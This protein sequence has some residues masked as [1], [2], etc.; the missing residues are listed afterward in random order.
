MARKNRAPIEQLRQAGKVA[1]EML[2]KKGI[3]SEKSIIDEIMTREGAPK[4]PGIPAYLPHQWTIKASQRIMYDIL[5][6]WK[7]ECDGDVVRTEN[8]TEFFK[9]V[10]AKLRDQEKEYN[11]EVA[12]VPRLFK[13]LKNIPVL[14]EVF[15]PLRKKEN[16]QAIQRF[17]IDSFAVSI[18]IKSNHSTSDY[19]NW[20]VDWTE[21]MYKIWSAPRE[22][23]KE[24]T[25]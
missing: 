22:D 17:F 10:I 20:F 1:Q 14:K 24:T 23:S 2:V 21:D 6:M 9:F 16:I 15:S 8:I 7:E 18:V 5:I 11:K 19:A 12:K 4:L 3:L 13:S 25:K